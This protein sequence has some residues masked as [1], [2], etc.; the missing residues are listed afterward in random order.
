MLSPEIIDQLENHQLPDNLEYAGKLEVFT[1]N[2]AKELQI[3]HDL[4]ENTLN[5][6]GIDNVLLEPGYDYHLGGISRWEQD[7]G[8]DFTASLAPCGAIIFQAVMYKAKIT[9]KETVSYRDEPLCKAFIL[10]E[11]ENKHTSEVIKR[12]IKENPV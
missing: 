7:V 2:E 12:F 5:D 11:P 4:F 6:A 9:R 8:I 3:P 1:S 10:W